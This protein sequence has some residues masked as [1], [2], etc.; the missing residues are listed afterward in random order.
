MVRQA[1][2]QGDHNDKRLIPLLACLLELQP[3]IKQWH[4]TS[5][6]EFNMSMADFFDGFIKEESRQLPRPAVETAE[7]DDAGLFPDASSTITYGWSLPEIQAWKPSTRRVAKRAA[8]KAAKKAATPKK[9]AKKRGKK[10][11][12]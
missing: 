2:Q 1:V 3:W 4:N 9:A 8:K 5:D 12:G 10:D 11:E 6:N 7:P